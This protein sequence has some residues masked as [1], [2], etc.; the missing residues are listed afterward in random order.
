MVDTPHEEPLCLLATT[1][2]CC[3]HVHEFHA[4]RQLKQL[5]GNRAIAWLSVKYAWVPSVW[6]SQ[7]GGEDVAYMHI[8]RCGNTV[9]IHTH[10]TEWQCCMRTHHTV[11]QSCMHAHH[12]VWQLVHL[13]AYSNCLKQMLNPRAWAPRLLSRMEQGQ[14]RMPLCGCLWNRS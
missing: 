14:L 10:R 13:K 3:T 1:T 8:I 7:E 9:C 5:R 4:V 6:P 12:T 2:R 11:W